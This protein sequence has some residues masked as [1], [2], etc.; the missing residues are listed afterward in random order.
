MDKPSEHS[1]EMP[2]RAFVTTLVAGFTLATGPVRADVIVTDANGLDAGTVDIPV[3]DGHIPAYRARP[4][5]RPQAPVVL[6]AQEVFGIHEHIKDLCRRLAHTGYYAIAPSLYARQGDPGKYDLAHVGDL[7]KDIVV[8]VPD[9]EVMSDL[10]ATVAFAQGEGADT[11]RLAITGFCWGGR[12]VWLYAAHNHAVKAGAAWYGPLAGTD[13]E[14]RPHTAIELAPQI[15]A[16]VLGLYAGHDENISAAD[17]DAMRQALEASGN[18]ASRIDVYADAQHGF[19]AD[20]RQSYN[21][22]DAKEGWSRMLAWFKANGV[23]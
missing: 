10:D 20:Y 15:K 7:I 21:A 13:N 22:A 8:K 1:F 6:V 16:P 12:V 11:A 2:R 4:A 18:S 14:L 3:S 17:I 9:A 23:G 19:N 5:G